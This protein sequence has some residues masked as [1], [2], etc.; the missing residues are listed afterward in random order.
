[1]NMS[2]LRLLTAGKCLI[3]LKKPEGRYHLPGNR[4]LPRFGPKKNPFRATVFPDK[5]DSGDAVSLECG[6]STP[7]GTEVATGPESGQVALENGSEVPAQQQEPLAEPGGNQVRPEV[8]R[9]GPSRSG[10]RALLLWSRARKPRGRIGAH[11][12]PWVQAELSLDAVKVVRN[13]LSESDLEVV[14]AR[15]VRLPDTTQDKSPAGR[16]VVGQE[17]G[18]CSFG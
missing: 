14:Q 6:S 16:S 4:S 3:G 1:M 15:S 7:H 5:P 13:D 10:L 11:G 8:K 17:A 12:R 2:L 9:E 18:P